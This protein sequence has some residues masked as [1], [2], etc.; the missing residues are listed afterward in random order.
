MSSLHLRQLNPSV[1]ALHDLPGAFVTEAVPISN[2]AK[3]SAGELCRVGGGLS[4]FGFGGT[5]DCFCIPFENFL[6]FD[7]HRICCSTGLL[8]A[9]VPPQLRNERARSSVCGNGSWRSLPPEACA[10]GGRGTPQVPSNSLREA[11][12]LVARGGCVSASGCLSRSLCP[13]IRDPCI[14]I[15]F[16]P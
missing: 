1:A 11:Q 10:Q 3:Q 9:G 14:E 15:S 4:S 13:N 6:W 12:L 2:L 16:E 8:A 7:V 5:S